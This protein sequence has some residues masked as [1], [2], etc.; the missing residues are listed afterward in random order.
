M[1][2]HQAPRLFLACLLLCGSATA[3]LSVSLTH[4]PEPFSPTWQIV[5]SDPS[6]SGAVFLDDCLINQARAGSQDGPLVWQPAFC[7]DVLI[8]LAP[9]GKLETTWSAFDSAGLPL[10]SGSYW[11]RT[12]Y[13]V[14]DSGLQH[15]WFEVEHVALSPVLRPWNAAMVGA[16][17]NLRLHAPQWAG[18]PYVAAASLGTGSGPQDGSA[19]LLEQDALFLLSLSEPSGPLFQGFQGN[20]DDFGSANGLSIALPAVPALA[21]VSFHLQAA[22][23]LPGTTT[24]PLR[25]SN[26][27]TVTIAPEPE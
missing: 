6:G 18:L 24:L 25:F 4:A 14:G 1:I 8:H 17:F 26:L 12:S 13:V 11:L 20:L 5:L 9:F 19:L 2:A 27:L 7:N 10:E 22:T 15:Q 23:G 21:G 16:A 3:Q